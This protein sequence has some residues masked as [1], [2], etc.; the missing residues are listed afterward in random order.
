MSFA[1]RIQYNLQRNGILPGDGDIIDDNAHE[2][3][4]EHQ[5]CHDHECTDCLTVYTDKGLDRIFNAGLKKLAERPEAEG[6]DTMNF[7]VDVFVLHDKPR[8]DMNGVPYTFTN[9][10]LLNDA[11]VRSGVQSIHDGFRNQG[12]HHQEDGVDVG[13]NF[14]LGDI[15]YVNGDEVWGEEAWQ[16]G[17]AWSGPG[18][19]PKSTILNHCKNVASDKDYSEGRRY[20]IILY[21][22]LNGSSATGFAWVSVKA[23]SYL[24]G[25]FVKTSRFPDLRYRRPEDEVFRQGYYRGAT[26]IHEIGHSLGCQHTFKDTNE[27]GLE[28]T[29]TTGDKILDTNSH[30]KGSLCGFDPNENPHNNYMSYSWYTK[31]VVFTAGQRDRMLAVGTVQWPLAFSNPEYI[32]EGGVAVYGCTDPT[33]GNYDPLVNIDDGSCQIKPVKYG[34]INPAYIEFDPDVTHMEWGSCKTLIGDTPEPISGCMSPEALNFNPL[35]TI[36]DGTCE[37]APDPIP[38]CMNPLATNYNPLATVDDGT[39][40]LPPVEILGCMNPLATNYNSKATKDDG[41]CELPPEEILGCTNPKATNYNPK[42]TK[43]DGSCEFTPE[44]ILGCTNP[45][46][47]N[48]NPKATKDDGSCELPSEGPIYLEKRV[49]AIGAE[50]YASFEPMPGFLGEL[51]T[52]RNEDGI[53][54]PVVS[55]ECGGSNIDCIL[56]NMANGKQYTLTSITD[57]VTGIRYPQ[58]DLPLAVHEDRIC[59]DFTKP[60]GGL[61]FTGFD[62]DDYFI[63]TLSYQ[64]QK[65]A[66]FQCHMVKRVGWPDSKFIVVSRSTKGGQLEWNN[67]QGNRLSNGGLVVVGDYNTICAS[68]TQGLFLNGEKTI[69]AGHPNDGLNDSD[70]VIGTDG[71]SPSRLCGA[72]VFEVTVK[73]SSLTEIEILSFELST[74]TDYEV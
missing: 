63:S 54:L 45:K 61:I 55:D 41:S 62:W 16:G 24:S 19:V 8:V 5:L 73:A 72:Y 12:A 56:S 36:D 14:G 53:E 58:D 17:V 43:D 57:Q 44:E 35:A 20:A 64:I 40:E 42:A 10:E 39:C 3:E 9:T 13:I 28:S 30:K 7:I 32:W 52:V 68:K 2:G 59:L 27:C 15:H 18:G 6:E 50:L 66:P 46:A 23:T 25:C 1:K 47:T 11:E 31:K 65:S 69:E 26:S 22:R 48:Y 74:M 38:G 51:C 67:T 71:N 33:M 60:S 37:F 21:P 4:H 70:L 49:E 34:C 29:A